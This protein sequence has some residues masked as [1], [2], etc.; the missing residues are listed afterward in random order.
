MGFP[1]VL[2]Q[3]QRLAAE[4]LR[5]GDTAVD[6]TVGNGVDTLFLARAVGPRGRVFAFDIQ[7]E[8]L[9]SA[10]RRFAAEGADDAAVVWLMRNHAEM[11]EAIPAALHGRL[12][13]AMFNLGYL[14]GGDPAVVTRPDST[15][16]ALEAAAELLRPRGVLTVVVYPGHPGGEEEAEAV[17][18]W[19]H[20]LPAASF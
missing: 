7:R 18:R 12:G 10:R 6:A 3:A 20:E 5:P 16:A 11:R 13:A 9:E 15:V 2:T 1:S 8:A 19:A 14:P 17:V 4:A